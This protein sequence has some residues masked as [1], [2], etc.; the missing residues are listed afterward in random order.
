MEDQ[1]LD[2]T[3]TWYGPISQHKLG[4]ETCEIVLFC[5]WTLSELSLLDFQLFRPCRED[6][7]ASLFPRAVSFFIKLG[8]F[9]YSQRTD[10]S[11]I[12][13]GKV[14]LAAL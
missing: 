3:W 5:G 1:Y 12:A 13:G 6:P 8:L 7:K 2:L 10:F 14:N 4:V 11:T 9:E